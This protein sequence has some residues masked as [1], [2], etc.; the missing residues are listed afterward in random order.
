MTEIKTR[1]PPCVDFGYF[2]LYCD[3]FRAAAKT[4]LTEVPSVTASTVM[5]NKCRHSTH[6]FITGR[7]YNE[8]MPMLIAGI[9]NNMQGAAG[10]TVKYRNM[11]FEGCTFCG[12]TAEDRGEDFINVTVELATIDIAN[13]IDEVVSP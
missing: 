13:F 4:V 12:Y 3:S 9:I 2:K 11:K 7:V 5:T 1:K 8:E 10:F 6:L